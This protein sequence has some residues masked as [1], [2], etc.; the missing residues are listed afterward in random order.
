MKHLQ[1]L[2]LHRTDCSGGRIGNASQEATTTKHVPTIK[3][4]EKLKCLG[5]D[6]IGIQSLLY[7]LIKYLWGKFKNRIV[8]KF[9][10]E[11]QQ[12]YGL[13]LLI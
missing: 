2:K 9:S 5:V 1:I 13:P 8:L 7:F 11:I 6:F 3:N 4:F 10:S 12:S